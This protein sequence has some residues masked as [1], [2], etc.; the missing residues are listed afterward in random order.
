[1]VGHILGRIL[2]DGAIEELLGQ[3]HCVKDLIIQRL[4]IVC[5]LMTSRRAP[6]ATQ[7]I[8]RMWTTK[9]AIEPS[10]EVSISGSLVALEVLLYPL[11]CRDSV[12]SCIRFNVA[13]CTTYWRCY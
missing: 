13:A 9:Q 3:S 7:S 5:D 11:T 8:R 4:C 1:M 2:R 10:L 6:T 12:I